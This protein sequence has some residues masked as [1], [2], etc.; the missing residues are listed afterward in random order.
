MKAGLIAT[1]GPEIGA[2]TNG[3]HV[4]QG[5]DPVVLAGI[6]APEITLALWQRSPC[7]EIS[8]WLTTVDFDAIEDLRFETELAALGD[9]V[10][11]GLMEAGYP[12]V[13]ARELLATDIADLARR[14][15]TLMDENHAVIRLEVVEDDACRRFHADY[16]TTRL[17]STYAGPGTE[18]LG[19]ADAAALGE[20]VPMSTLTIHR[21]GTGDVG[22]FKGRLWAP[23]NAISHRSPPIAGTG[24]RRL[25]LVIDPGKEPA[26]VLA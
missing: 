15:L 9:D 24:K 20:G 21:L 12:D 3:T 8:D 11:E 5:T 1:T 26:A 13:A 23:E 2:G 16:V 7:A 18:W 25:V 10:R 14:F 19:Q 17:I 22:L 4:V 6:R